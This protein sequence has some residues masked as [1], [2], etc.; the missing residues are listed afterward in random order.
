MKDLARRLLAQDLSRREFARGMAALGF[1]A[2]AIQ[3]AFEFASAADKT[4]SPITVQA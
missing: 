2:A 3:S 1:G 4:G